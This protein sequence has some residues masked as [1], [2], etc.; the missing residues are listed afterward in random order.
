MILF[1][2]FE[3]GLRVS[4]LNEMNL[5]EEFKVKIKIKSN[6]LGHLVKISLPHGSMGG[7]V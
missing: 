6:N 2:Y 3:V 7:I 4:L 5:N 1:V